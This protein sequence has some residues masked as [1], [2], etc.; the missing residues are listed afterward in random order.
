MRDP[1]KT[2]GQLILQSGPVVKS[3]AP[4]PITIVPR[5]QGDKLFTLP[6][7]PFS[8]LE[9]HKPPGPPLSPYGC[10]DI[11]HKPSAEPERPAPSSAVVRV[12]PDLARQWLERNKRNRPIKPS[13]VKLYAL[14]MKLG[15]WRLNGESIIFDWN[16][17]I[18]TGQHRLL[19][20]IEADVTF[21]TLAVFNIDPETVLTIDSGLRQTN[22]D[23]LSR[24][25]E[26]STS[27]LA[28]ALALLDK[29]R[30]GKLGERWRQLEREDMEDL[31]GANPGLRDA[32]SESTTP[33]MRDIMTNSLAGFFR[34]IFSEID[35]E[36]GPRFMD[37]L[38]DGAGMQ[39]N[40]PVQVLRDRLLKVRATPSTRM[41]EQYIIALT[42]LAWNLRRKGR[43]IGHKAFN[44]KPEDQ[45][46]PNPI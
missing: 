44:W 21:D 20:C 15:R 2:L 41:D 24:D 36:A 25:G 18:L 19:A 16:G 12:T 38:R 43:K 31:L 39:L 14:R 33:R 3:T 6:G 13:R 7:D 29:Y 28:H 40:D 22:A 34:Y 1:E 9:A 42:I 26:K 4:L 37:D 11:P 23:I 35:P 5:V 17:D 32:I 10:L 30:N 45:S 46:F 27:A 8:I